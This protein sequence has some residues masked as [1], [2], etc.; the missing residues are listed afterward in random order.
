MDIEISYLTKNKRIKNKD[1]TKIINEILKE[2]GG[3]IKLKEVII[4]V[5]ETDDSFVKEKMGG[6][7]GYA[8]FKNIIQLEICSSVKAWKGELRN[9][10]VHEY[11]HLCV[12]HYG[13]CGEKLLDSIIFEGMAENFRDDVL[14]GKP[15]P[16]ATALSM[17]EM[18]NLLKRIKKMLGSKDR[19]IYNSLFFEG[20][21]YKLWS[22]YSLGYHL[23]KQFRKNHK[24]LTWNNLVKVKPS[25]ILKDFNEG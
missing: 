3:K 14:G 1:T 19:K 8:R 2:C 4:A 11:N 10:I 20:K 7:T 12:Y 5:Y 18:K 13:N 23:V 22:G 16:W 21:K 24:K 17:T 9:T 6:V 25:E 15:S